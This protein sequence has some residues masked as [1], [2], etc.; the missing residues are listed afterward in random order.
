MKFAVLEMCPQGEKTMNSFLNR[1]QKPVLLEKIERNIDECINTNPYYFKYIW[2]N[3]GENLEEFN[4]YVKLDERKQSIKDLLNSLVSDEKVDKRVLLVNSAFESYAE[5]IESYAGLHGH[6]GGLYEYIAMV[7]IAFILKQNLEDKYKEYICENKHTLICASKGLVEDFEAYIDSFTLDTE[8]RFNPY[9]YI[10][11]LYKKIQE[12]NA[13]ETKYSDAGNVASQISLP[14]WD[15]TKFNL[16]H[17][18]D[19]AKD[20]LNRIHDWEL[21]NGFKLESLQN[22]DI[23]E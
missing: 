10:G 1:T 6:I 12:A 19:M 23:E 16:D 5:K 22:N 14:L 21:L 17:I 11:S 13:D 9:I 18:I 15:L 8:E 4:K 3:L 7:S 2:D 20:H